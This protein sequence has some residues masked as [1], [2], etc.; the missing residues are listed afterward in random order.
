M[1]RIAGINVAEHKHTEIALTA[2]FG[3]G[4]QTA[5][6]ICQQVEID[7]TV[8]IKDLSEEQLESIRKVVSAFDC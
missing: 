7:P 6:E 4:R 2:I 5:Q 3:V 8:K 1:A